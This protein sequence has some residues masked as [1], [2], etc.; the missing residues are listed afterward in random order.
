M[1]K[2][3]AKTSD[4]CRS[5]YKHHRKTSVGNPHSNRRAE[6]AVKTAK[7]LLR[8]SLPLDGGLN[9][10]ALS[11]TISTY[12]NTPDCDT[13]LSQVQPTWTR[14]GDA[15]WRELALAKRSTANQE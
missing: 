3:I 13:G 2:D 10:I 8:E 1:T 5:C 7:T 9:T 15:D 11:K 4:T 12:R 14:P 6:I